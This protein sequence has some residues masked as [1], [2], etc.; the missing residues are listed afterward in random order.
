MVQSDWWAGVLAL[1]GLVL[2]PQPSFAQ[3]TKRE[4]APHV[5]GHAKAN[6]AIESGRVAVELIAPGAD[7]VGFEHAP[8]TAEQKSAVEKARKALK[9]VSGI[10]SFAA[11]AGCRVTTTKVAVTGEEEHGHGANRHHD[12][13]HEAKE[14]HHHGH[15]EKHDGNH[16]EFHAEYM[17]ACKNTSAIRRIGFPYLKRFPR[18]EELDVTVLSAHGQKAYEVTPAKPEISLERTR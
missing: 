1:A 14:K 7:V 2:M 10:I 11:E 17:F 9:D 6:I 3:E 8:K 12:H 16:N 18:T 4:M 15:A 13:A 5:H